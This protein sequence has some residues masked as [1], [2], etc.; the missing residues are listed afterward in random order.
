MHSAVVSVTSVFK[1]S[2]STNKEERI[3]G[4]NPPAQSEALA[5]GRR[6]EGEGAN[7]DRRLV[8][9]HRKCKRIQSRIEF[10]YTVEPQNR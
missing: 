4:N 9:Y 7:L 2:I 5:E 3:V 10:I 6:P 1:A 8:P